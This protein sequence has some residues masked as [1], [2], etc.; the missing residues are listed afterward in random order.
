MSVEKDD[1]EGAEAY[2]FTALFCIS[3]LLLLLSV[4]RLTQHLRQ[5]LHYRP[6]VVLYVLFIGFTS[7]RSVF[8]ADVWGNYSYY[9]YF[10]LEFAP[11]NLQFAAEVVL[12]FIW[13]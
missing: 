11:N 10:F 7:L 9:V 1:A 4:L 8:F 13:Y 2:S 5:Q 6:L 12:C 3:L